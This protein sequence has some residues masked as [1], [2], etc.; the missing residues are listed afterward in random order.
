M[1]VSD[2]LG[3]VPVASIEG[4][5]VGPLIKVLFQFLHNPVQ[6]PHADPVFDPVPVV[7]APARKFLEKLRQDPVQ[8]LFISMKNR[9]EDQ[10]AVNIV[11][12]LVPKT[13]QDIRI[14]LFFV[15]AFKVRNPGLVAG[16]NAGHGRGRVMGHFRVISPGRP[17]QEGHIVLGVAV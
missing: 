15:G 16:L 11:H 7:M 6:P 1:A 9:P 5:V 12:E 10:A 17:L 3:V 2:G 13:P 4:H 14:L 8:L